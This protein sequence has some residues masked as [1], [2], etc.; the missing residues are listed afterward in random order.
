MAGLEFESEYE[1]TEAATSSPL[2]QAIAALQ[3]YRPDPA[4]PLEPA[5]A[6]AMVKIGNAW[7]SWPETVFVLLPV[8]Q[9]C[10]AAAKMG[11]Q[12]V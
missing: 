12:L 10:R 9:N 11:R 2:N 8:G 5:I 1:F 3:R 7:N 6:K 4:F